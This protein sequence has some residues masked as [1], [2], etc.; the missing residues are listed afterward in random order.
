MSACSLSLFAFQSCLGEMNVEDPTSQSPDA[1]SQELTFGMDGS[2]E[3]QKA[4]DTRAGG[5]Q[6][7]LVSENSI[8]YK[9]KIE[10]HQFILQ[11][12]EW[13]GI[14]PE[15]TGNTV[16]AETR[17]TPVPADDVLDFGVYTY[18]SE[19]GSETTPPPYDGTKSK[20]YMANQFVDISE[21]YLY[22][23]VRY[24]PGNRYWVNFF[25]Y[26]PYITNVNKD[27]ETYLTL[28]STD[29]LPVMT[30][31]VPADVA[32]QVD[33]LAASTETFSGDYRKTVELPFA[34]MLSA[35][36]FKVGS[37]PAVEITE[38]SLNNLVSKGSVDINR[39][40]VWS[41]LTGNDDFTQPL[42]GFNAAENA[43]KQ[44]GQTYFLLP[45]VFEDD[46]ELSITIRF[47]ADDYPRYYTLTVPL[48]DL[49]QEW[50][51]GHTYVYTLTTP[52]EVDVEIEEDFTPYGKTKE[53]VYFEN[54]GLADLQIRAAI[55]G[56]W[57]VRR[58]I[59]GV[60]RECV[61]S[62]WKPEEDGVFAGFPGD[63]WTLAEDGY[64]YYGQAIKR[65]EKTNNLF[66]SYTLT[67]TPPVVGA[68][69]VLTIVGQARLNG[70]VGPS[71]DTVSPSN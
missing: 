15:V 49:C 51:K 36:V 11:M 64:Y 66:D 27:D 5:S 24:W 63:G 1:Y 3:W 43:G 20:E 12:T 48:K 46:D 25:A 60:E 9:D 54:K 65:G 8:S 50:K 33:L 47:G 57:I 13:E 45:Q 23:P 58:E 52:D 21:G 68:E 32:D 17:A 29:N 38:L 55:V 30:Y 53:N 39:D 7:R 56:Y 16:S 69:L 26:R 37:I 44:I 67:S 31:S 41:G 40:G 62:A 71:W 35:I 28:D 70:V 61:V 34:H 19:K 4:P 10:G 59:N 22:S 14:G 6:T 42:T 18:V 2:D